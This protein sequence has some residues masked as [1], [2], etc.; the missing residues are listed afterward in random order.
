MLLLDTS[1]IIAYNDDEP[2]IVEYI[3]GREPFFTNFET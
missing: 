3:D 2:N 1:A